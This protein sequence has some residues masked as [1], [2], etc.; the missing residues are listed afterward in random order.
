MIH[1]RAALSLALIWL[2]LSPLPGRADERF[3][4]LWE[5]FEHVGEGCP[6]GPNCILKRD[7]KSR[8]LGNGSTQNLYR[9][10]G[11]IS[12]GPNTVI[13][14]SAHP[15]APRVCTS[16][17]TQITLGFDPEKT[18]KSVKIEALRG[19]DAIFVDLRAIKSPPGYPD[20]FGA[21]IHDEFVAYLENAGLRVLDE[22]Q[23]A[24]EPGQPR[25]SVFF[26]FT[27]RDGTCDYVYSVFASLAQDVLLSRDLRIK[28]SAGVWSFSTSSTAANHS[29]TERDAILQ[30]AQA[31]VRD[32]QQVNPR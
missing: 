14:P 32:H 16:S 24:R 1:L 19:I 25:L 12:P 22:T 20:H 23:I 6:N 3:W 8:L 28:V 18:P 5:R 10:F 31:L 17:D 9:L 15:L 2:V 7:F 29:G 26:S 13:P 27:D 21:S 30:V 11:A 4:V